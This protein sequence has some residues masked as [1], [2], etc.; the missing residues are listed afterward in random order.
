MLRPSGNPA[1]TSAP[2]TVPNDPDHVMLMASPSGSNDWEPS[3]PTTAPFGAVASTCEPAL[4]RAIG[5]R[6]T[7]GATKLT[8]SGGM[9]VTGTSVMIS[10]TIWPTDAV[11]EYVASSG[12]P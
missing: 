10:C 4:T 2:S 11:T 5:T 9:F 12:A 7:R 8:P 6:L 3:R 1:F